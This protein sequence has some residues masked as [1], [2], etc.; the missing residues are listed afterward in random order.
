MALTAATY[1]R[2]SMGSLTLNIVTFATVTSAGDTWTS[3]LPNAV[4]YWA[5]ATTG[6]SPYIGCNVS[7]AASTGIFTITPEQTSDVILYV[8]TRT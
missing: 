7:F 5:N 1:T 6:S 8:G 2:E 3:G 4:A